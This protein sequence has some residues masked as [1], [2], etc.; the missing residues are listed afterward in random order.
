M[1]S[2]TTTSSSIDRKR[3][4]KNITLCGNVTVDG[5]NV[6]NNTIYQYSEED[7][8][9]D[10]FYDLIDD[11]DVSMGKADTIDVCL[12]RKLSS[13]EVFHPDMEEA[14]SV[15]LNFDKT[16]KYVTF[17]VKKFSA[18]KLTDT[19]EKPKTNAF[20]ALMSNSA[21][22]KKP[23]LKQTDGARFTGVYVYSYQ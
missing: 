22:E 20:V 2:P 17:S 1:S 6:I 18:E 7:T 16:L 4:S 21:C 3:S 12:T 5:N 13:P 19:S 10:V 14:I 23:Q 9:R 15:A 8:W 11:A